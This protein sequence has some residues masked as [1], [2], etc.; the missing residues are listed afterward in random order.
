VTAPLV[1][2]VIPTFNGGERLLEALKSVADQETD[3]EY[4]IVAIDSGSTD[5]TL[6]ALRS[7]TNLVVEVDPKSF[8]HGLTRNAAIRASRGELVALLV[9]DAVPQNPRWLTMLAEPLRRDSRIAG[10]FCRQLPRPDASPITKHY[11]SLWVAA[12]CD[13]R[14]IFLDRQ[15]YDASS[16]FERLDACA[17]DNVSSI[18]RRTIWEEHPFRETPIGEDVIWAREVLLAGRGIAYVPDAVVEH[19]HD[20]SSWYELK[21]TWMLHEQLFSQFG[22][23]T[24]PTLG[25]LFT[26][27]L[28]SLALHR[29]CENLAPANGR[30][31][32][33]YLRNVGLAFA[34]PAGQY[35]GAMSA[36][37]GR[38]RWR[39]RGV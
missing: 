26:A 3:F 6:P 13:P 31:V 29:R 39:P 15:R 32:R 33:A 5:G 19:S 12:R 34:W 21:R 7:R 28:S 22:L 18:V 16:P 17:F 27:V 23:R 35:L 4:E 8:D 2:V 14:V 9:Q 37:T 25:H 24:I 30:S 1:S 10:A 20:R 36:A 11:L 38:T